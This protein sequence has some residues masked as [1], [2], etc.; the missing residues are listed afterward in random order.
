M[1]EVG[2]GRADV[3]FGIPEVGLGTGSLD[4]RGMELM[5]FCEESS[6]MKIVMVVA[7]VGWREQDGGSADVFKER[8]ARKDENG[9]RQRTVFFV[10]KGPCLASWV[11]EEDVFLVLALSGGQPTGRM[12]WRREL[13]IEADKSYSSQTIRR[14]RVS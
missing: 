11:G 5:R 13:A 6:M 2:L 14:I 8:N 7:R 3:G 10:P 9:V 1:T 12:G 4:S